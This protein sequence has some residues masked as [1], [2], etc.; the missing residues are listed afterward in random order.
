MIEN[1][2]SNSNMGVT[3]CEGD[4]I[5]NQVLLSTI[6]TKNINS[7]KIQIKSKF[8]EEIASGK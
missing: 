1:A 6:Y 4:Y 7:L 8:Y 5:H 2:K 3:K